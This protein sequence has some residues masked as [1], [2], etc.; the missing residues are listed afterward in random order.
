MQINRENGH[1]NCLIKIYMYIESMMVGTKVLCLL[2]D[3]IEILIL[4]DSSASIFPSL[5]KT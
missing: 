5:N 3:E 1:E 4:V 2:F